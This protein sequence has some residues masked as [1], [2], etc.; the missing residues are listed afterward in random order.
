MLVKQTDNFDLVFRAV[1]DTVDIGL[2]VV[3]SMGSIVGWNEWIARVSRRTAQ[4]VVGKS[5]EDIFP[6]I[7]STRLPSV[8]DDAFQVG[9]SSVLTHTLNE[10]LPLRGEGGERLLHNIVVRPVRSMNA[11]YCLLQITDVTVAVTR[12]RVL[13]ERQ[14]ARYHAIVDSAPDAIIT[15]DGN[16]TI[17][18]V[19]GAVDHILGYEHSDLLGRNLDLL[20]EQDNSLLRAL[21]K[22]SADQKTQATISVV[23]RYKNGT[24]GHFEVSVGR[25]RADQRDFVTTIWRDVTERVAANAALRDARDALQRSN[26]E[27][28]T[29]VEQRTRERET[30]LRQ[31]HESQKMESIGQLTGGVAHDFNNL[32]A[33][34][35][36]SLGLLKKVVPN[37]PRVSRL[38][39]RAIQGAERGATL[40]ARLLAFARRQELKV[41]FVELQKLIPDMLDFLR[42]SVG[43]SIVI[44]AEVSPE[45]YAIEVDANQLELA[46]INLAVNAR[47]AMP[48]GGALTIACQNEESGKKAGLPPNPFVCISVTDTG[49]GMS[50]AT[51]ARAQEPFFTTKGVGKGTGLGLSM[52]QGF[53]AQSGGAMQIQSE[54]AKGTKVTL[55]LPRAREGLR[56]SPPLIETSQPAEAKCLRV[57]LVDDDILVSMGAA[58]MLADLG[59]RVIEAQSGIHAMEILET[60]APFDVVVTDYAMPGM[61]GFELAQRIRMRNPRLPIILA[62]GYAE[63]PADRSIQFARLS[64]PYSANDLAVAL[65]QAVNS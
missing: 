2:V 16:H 44:H 10:L 41:E 39:D 63:L 43:P 24:A 36:G 54:P 7:H 15:V 58:D 47:D 57:L 61:N 14:N 42:H 17:Q 19:N 53:T 51:L 56:E 5:L 52:V 29:R 26:E 46:L 13:R 34:I 59:H 32:L 40:T 27:L 35:L 22:T 18:W 55:W 28:E 37:D 25:W 6:E 21:T 23:G 4:D 31:L 64:K 9:S 49:A 11:N 48:N 38:L 65:E 60:D 45:V 20:L 33:V 30:A 50:E 8:I 1:F 12:E 3:D 62:T